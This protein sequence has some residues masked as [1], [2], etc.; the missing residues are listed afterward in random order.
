MIFGLTKRSFLAFLAAAAALVIV[1]CGGEPEALPTQP[2]APTST[3]TPVPVPTPTSTI[4]PTIQVASTQAP[5][6]TLSPTVTP[7][8]TTRLAPATAT[9]AP[10]PTPVATEGGLFLQLADPEET[11]VFT[12]EPFLDVVGRTR[13]DAVVTINDTVVEPDVNGQFLLTVALEEGPN[14]IEVVASVASG[15]QQDLVLVA[16][17]VP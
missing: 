1:A 17:Y 14:I 4:V 16:F 11:E 2:P 13:V 12:D 6:A 9:L 8:P 5:T 3:P 10:N 7:A 15:E